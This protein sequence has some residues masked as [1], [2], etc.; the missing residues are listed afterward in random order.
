MIIL[1]YINKITYTYTTS[2]NKFKQASICICIY[3]YFFYYYIIKVL[4]FTEI[5]MIFYDSLIFNLY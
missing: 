5:N 4:F 2:L 3:I 1:Y